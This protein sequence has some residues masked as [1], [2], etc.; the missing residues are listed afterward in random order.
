MSALGLRGC[1]R[2][3]FAVFADTGDEPAYVYRHL[4]R[5]QAFGAAHDLPVHIVRGRATLSAASLQSRRVQVPAYTLG[6]DG[7]AVPLRRTCTSDYKLRPIAR[8]ISRQLGL[9]LGQRKPAD[10]VTALLGIS[11]EEAHRMRDASR[12]SPWIRNQYPLVDAGMTRSAC[13]GVL[14]EHGFHDVGRSACL[15][16]PFHSDRYWRDLRADHPVDFDR[17]VAFDEAIREHSKDS[18]RKVYLHRSLV[19]L[20]LVD[21]ST[22]QQD[23]FGNECSGSCGV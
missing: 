15:F 11:V 8:F 7:D 5:L 3:Q 16:C 12:V 19:P 20:R 6:S 1:D 4:E 21:F 13:H 18:S 10:T 2:A 17:A 14:E 23:L 22:A 9:R